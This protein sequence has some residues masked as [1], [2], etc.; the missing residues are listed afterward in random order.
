MIIDK[1]IEVNI[2]EGNCKKYEKIL[3]IDLVKGQKINISQLDLLPMSREKVDCICDG[4]GIQ[5]SKERASLKSKSGKTYC[6]K[7]CYHKTLSKS[8]SGEGNPNPKKRKVRVVCN[9][10]NKEFLVFESKYKSQKNF[11]CSRECYAKHRSN[12]YHGS[13]VYNYQDIKVKCSASNCNN[14]VETYKWKV[15]NRRHL[16]CS[17]ECYYRHREEF[18][19]DF[20]YNERFREHSYETIPEK[21]V[22][23]WLEE[24]KIDYRQ[25]AG[26]LKKYFV[27][28]Y[29]P[30][31]KMILEVNGDYWHVNPDVY[32]IYGNDPSKKPLNNNQYEFLKRDKIRKKDFS[33]YNYEYVEIWEKEIHE[34]LDETMNNI[35][36]NRSLTT[37]RNA[38]KG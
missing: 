22:K 34:N 13:N 12:V 37:T 36:N 35:F 38:P 3:G 5:F 4:C 32:D 16:F 23:K 30:D 26:F 19:T 18:Y 11:L 24:N 10:C 9:N 2:V 8:F 33:K 6:N 25:E 20:Y 17:P 29:L 31:Y 21:M 27:D 14:I 7:S 1:K 28:F 15:D